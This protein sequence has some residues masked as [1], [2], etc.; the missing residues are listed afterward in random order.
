MGR[1]RKGGGGG[2]PREDERAEGR[3]RDGRGECGGVT[4]PAS[5]Q[6]LGEAPFIAPHLGPFMCFVA[7]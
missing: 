4:R 6:S 7:Q 1:E 5:L 3:E 2:T